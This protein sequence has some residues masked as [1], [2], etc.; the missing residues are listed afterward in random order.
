MN[1]RG[2]VAVVQDLKVSGGEA[3]AVVVAAKKHHNVDANKEG[4]AKKKVKVSS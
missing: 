1:G 4:V 3:V 2:A